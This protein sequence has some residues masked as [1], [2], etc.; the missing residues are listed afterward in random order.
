LLLFF[1]V[2]IGASL[3]CHRWFERPMQQ[4]LRQFGH[5]R[6]ANGVIARQ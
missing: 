4:W 5:G 6:L 1:L 2:L 3:I